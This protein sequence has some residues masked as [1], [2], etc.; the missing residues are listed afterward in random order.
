[1][2]NTSMLNTGRVY[3][4]MNAELKQV[5]WDY[6]FAGKAT[7]E[8][9]NSFKQI[10]ENSIQMN[11]PVR[12]VDQTAMRKNPW[13]TK[14]TKRKILRMNKAWKLYRTIPTETNYGKYKVLRNE[15]NKQIKDDQAN[16]RKKILKSFK[17]KLHAETENSEGQ[18]CAT[19]WG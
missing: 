10:L 8:S 9:W 17:G 4:Q 5:N 3:S 15:A 12:K 7:E 16:Y 1:M 19:H 2:P 6:E 14:P 18:G 13:M 11:V